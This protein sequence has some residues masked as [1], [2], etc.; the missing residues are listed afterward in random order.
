MTQEQNWDSRAEHYDKLFWTKDKDYIE[1]I[2]KI[3]EFEKSDIVLDIGVGTGAVANE[4]SKKVAHVVGLDISGMMLSKGNWNGIS[5]IKW[6]IRNSL[7]AH[8]VFDKIIARM[9]FHHIIDNIEVAA[10]RCYDNLKAGGKI[11]IAEG[12]PPTD[13]QDIFIW[14]A[15]MFRLKEERRTF[16]KSM[17]VELLRHTGFKNI[18][19]TEY[20]MQD[21]DI[22]NW[23]ENSG[24]DEVI[25]DRIKSIH[26]LASNKVK[27][28]YNMKIDNGKIYVDTRKII[29]T[30]VK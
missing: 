11:V 21:F 22:N 19:I 12:I 9:V 1:L 7:F 14:Y 20:I 29:V 23:L 4:I 15:D 26:I 6:D 30:G 13:D 5:L 2:Y 27:K 10:M 28:A 25:Q 24:L 17:L 16:N 8:N 18:I 3:C